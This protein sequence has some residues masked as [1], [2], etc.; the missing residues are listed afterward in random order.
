MMHRHF[1]SIDS[2]HLYVLQN[3]AEL[4]RECT[5]AASPVLVTADNQPAGVGRFH[6]GAAATWLSAPGNLFASA[7][8]RLDSRRFP[9]IF[10][11]PLVAVASLLDTL[12]E[13]FPEKA[14]QLKVKFINDLYFAGKKAGGVLC[15]LPANANGS[16]TIFVGD[17][18]EEV[19]LETLTERL[20][21]QETHFEYLALV[22]FGTN[23]MEHPADGS[24]A[25]KEFGT[26]H[27]DA[28]KHTN[29]NQDIAKSVA[30]LIPQIGD[31]IGKSFEFYNDLFLKHLHA[32]PQSIAVSKS[33]GGPLLPVRLSAT[34]LTHIDIQ[35]ATLSTDKESFY[36]AFSS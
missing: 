23:L 30:Q 14:S 25:L 29:L 28:S 9:E 20:A 2:T 31:K 26:L 32:P 16:Y 3:F 4:A 35:R 15:H 5:S 21:A 10:A 36:P 12:A 34:D 17:A 1:S 6:D 24:A 22:S 11:L 18:K 33:A 13:R 7:L 27:L 8:I 19:S